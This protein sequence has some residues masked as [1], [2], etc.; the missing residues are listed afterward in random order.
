M[1]H[2]MPVKHYLQS[3]FACQR[4]RGTKMADKWQGYRILLFSAS[5]DAAYTQRH[6]TAQA[7]IM[8]SEP[9]PSRQQKMP[10]NY[11]VSH[12]EKKYVNYVACYL[13]LSIEERDCKL[14]SEHHPREIN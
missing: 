9:L 6:H 13:Q 7:F 2:G 1:R 4:H 3:F 5:D 11:D 8:V 12:H 10:R 14:V